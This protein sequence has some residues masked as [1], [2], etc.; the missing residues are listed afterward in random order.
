MKIKTG[1]FLLLLSLGLLFSPALILAKNDNAADQPPDKEGTYDIPGHPNLKLRVFVHN[2]RPSPTPSPT[3]SCSDLDS[4]AKVDPAGWHLPSG[5]WNY[6]LNNSSVPSSVGSDK[7]S[8]IASD[9][10]SPWSN[11][12]SNQVTFSEAGTILLSKAQLDGKNIISWGK[13]P[14]S[15]LAITYIWYNR[16]SGDVTELDT[17]MNQRFSWSWTPYAV[18]LCGK[19]NTYDA[20]DIL[21]HELGHWLGLNDEYNASYANNTMYG[22]GAKAEI[23][24]DTLTTGDVAGVTSIY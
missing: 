6:Y 12:I 20:Q 3:L 8:E 2:P 21:T 10:F 4:E 7:L 23:N 14:G 19:A 17:I 18:N 16:T 15:A 9:A 22:Y 13:A 1:L 11:A 24:K 5:S